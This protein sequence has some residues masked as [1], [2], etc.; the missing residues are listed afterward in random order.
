[1]P[2][3]KFL[4]AESNHITSFLGMSHQPMLEMISLE[5]NSVSDH[6]YF[7]VMALLVC[8]ERLNIINHAVVTSDEREL[9]ARLGGSSGVVARCL[10]YG[11]L[12]FNP[13]PMP[14]HL[15]DDLMVK[16]KASYTNIVLQLD[17]SKSVGN[18]LAKHHVVVA[19]PVKQYGFDFPVQQQQHHQPQQQYQQQPQ[20]SASVSPVSFDHSIT[21]SPLSEL[22]PK[23]T[24]ND[25]KR[26]QQPPN[27]TTTPVPQ[28]QQQPQPQ[29]QQ[30]QLSLAPLPKHTTHN[31]FVSHSPT[32]ALRLT[33]PEL[34][35]IGSI[36]LFV[37]GNNLSVSVSG[38]DGT[39]KHRT[40]LSP[41]ASCT[42]HANGTLDF[43]HLS[44][45]TAFLR[46][47][48]QSAVDL[49]LEDNG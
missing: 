23:L 6:P 20:Q 28:S 16:L 46:L 21:S 18:Y 27:P 9:A 11:W 30:Q 7:R 43:T 15:Y 4:H 40:V 29:Q 12:D 42:V 45:P 49:M 36:T 1:M 34:T 47:D 48:I 13:E 31:N 19:P 39:D 17:P 2:S 32:S 44:T 24:L 38:M 35:A 37:Y 8:G 26:H 25:L 5:G 10:S 3:L 33:I 41:A 22:G 14:R